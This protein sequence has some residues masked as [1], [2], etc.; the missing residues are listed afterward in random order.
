M[1]LF[2]MDFCLV[3]LF[4][5]NPDNNNNYY[6]YYVWG[7]PVTCVRRHLARFHS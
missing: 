2:P 4:P 3:T 7:L 1:L 6:Y 5:A